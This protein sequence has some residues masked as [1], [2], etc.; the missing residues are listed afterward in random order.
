VKLA[1]QQVR[2]FAPFGTVQIL[3]GVPLTRLHIVNG[4]NVVESVNVETVVK[5]IHKQLS[6]ST[7]YLRAQEFCHRFL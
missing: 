3:E 6:M 1:Y 5:Y 4:L 2:P 7:L